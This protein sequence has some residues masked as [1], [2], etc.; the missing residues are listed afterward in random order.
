MQRAEAGL[1]GHLLLSGVCSPRGSEEDQGQAGVGEFVE[2]R[3]CGKCWGVQWHC[4]GPVEMSQTSCSTEPWVGSAPSMWGGVCVS[5]TLASW[6][7]QGQQGWLMSITHSSSALDL[8]FFHHCRYQ[9]DTRI[10]GGGEAVDSRSLAPG[11][12]V[13]RPGMGATC[14]CDKCPRTS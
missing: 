5:A 11:F 6:R 12:G 10:T 3:R 7:T 1:G 9:T 14:I 8:Q 2:G 4:G 13:T